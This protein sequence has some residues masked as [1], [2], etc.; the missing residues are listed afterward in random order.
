MC[1]SKADGG[2]RCFG[3]AATRYDNA[4]MAVVADP[5]NNAKWDAFA[6]ARVEYASTPKGEA[7]LRDQVQIMHDEGQ[8]P[9]TIKDVEATI[10]RGIMLRERNAAV[11]AA[12]QPATPVTPAP[13]AAAESVIQAG[14]RAQFDALR[15]PEAPPAAEV[16]PAVPAANDSATTHGPTRK[17]L[18]GLR[19]VR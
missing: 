3:H 9:D 10:E 19:R 5:Y 2:Q 15:T 14:L 17:R 12:N 7:D 6:T 16:P 8:H 18:K 11:K 13:T 1:N 4:R